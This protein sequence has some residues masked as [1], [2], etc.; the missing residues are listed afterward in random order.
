MPIQRHEV[1]GSVLTLAV[2]LLAP[3]VVTIFVVAFALYFVLTVLT[4]VGF[5]DI[6]ATSHAARIL[7]MVQMVLDV[8][9]L[10]A[11]V[12]LVLDAGRKAGGASD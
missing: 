11:V 7:V 12:R 9:L 4:T 2:G 8:T 5:G 10:V 6:S 3:C 1:L